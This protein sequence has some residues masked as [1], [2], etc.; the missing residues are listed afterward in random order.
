MRAS[1]CSD[2]GTR[3]CHAGIIEQ[4]PHKIITGEQILKCVNVTIQSVKSSTSIQ[5]LKKVITFEMLHVLLTLSGIKG[6]RLICKLYRVESGTDFRNVSKLF[7]CLRVFQNE[8]F[9]PAKN[10]KIQRY[11]V[12]KFN[13][14]RLNGYRWQFDRKTYKGDIRGSVNYLFFL[15]PDFFLGISEQLYIFTPVQS[16]LWPFMSLN[17]RTAC[18]EPKRV[19]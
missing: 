17:V 2:I 12:R 4:L 6:Q 8:W 19:L 7:T 9:E 10:V 14:H 15:N 13:R 11:N 1:T 16:Y 18:L 5:G 3:W